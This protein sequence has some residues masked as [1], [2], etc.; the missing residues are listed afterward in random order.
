MGVAARV[1]APGTKAHR[2]RD[3]HKLALDFLVVADA[4]I[5]RLP[6]GRG[7]QPAGNIEIS[8]RLPAEERRDRLVVVSKA[9]FLPFGGAILPRRDSAP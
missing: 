1:P 3:A 4:P 5:E 7:Q 6:R 2:R 9:A 8:R